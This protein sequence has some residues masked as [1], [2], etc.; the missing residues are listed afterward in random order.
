MTGPTQLASPSERPRA[1]ASRRTARAGPKLPKTVEPSPPS[2]AQKQCGEQ[3]YD[4]PTQFSWEVCVIRASPA[5]HRLPD[6]A[7]LGMNTY[8]CLF[9][10]PT[11]AGVTP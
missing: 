3:F 1:A 8:V 11:W 4:A 10:G 7:E 2:A 6:L 5:Q 9:I